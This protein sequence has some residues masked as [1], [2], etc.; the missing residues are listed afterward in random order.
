M[1]TISTHAVNPAGQSILAKCWRFVVD[2]SKLGDHPRI[3]RYIKLIPGP[4]LSCPNQHQRS[5]LG[6]QSEFPTGLLFVE[7]SHG[8]L[9]VVLDQKQGINID[10]R[11]KWL[12]QAIEAISYIHSRGVIHS[13]LRPD[14]F[15][16]YGPEMDLR[17][18]D[19]GGSTCKELNLSGNKLPDAGFFNPES[20]WE[21]SFAIDIFSLGSVLYTIIAGHWPFRENESGGQ[22]ETLEEMEVYGD[23]VEEQFANHRFPD[24]EQIYKGE[25]IL[26]CW[27][28]QF[29]S[30]KD[31]NS[32]MTSSLKSRRA[33]LP[34]F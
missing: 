13:D 6:W 28:V 22:F 20:K 1:K 25:I 16:I 8:N 30:I 24:T 2:Q 32:T 9:Q 33:R 27:T 10:L 17:L 19:F 5:Y 21:P 3:V 34:E 18:C 14:N 31:L 7:A 4:P 23:Y 11:I 26:G 12:H 15:L 29:P